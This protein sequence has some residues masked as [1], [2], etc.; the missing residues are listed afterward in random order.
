[1]LSFLDIDYR[2][3]VMKGGGGRG[4]GVMAKKGGARFPITCEE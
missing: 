1:M 4:R 2:P 3:P